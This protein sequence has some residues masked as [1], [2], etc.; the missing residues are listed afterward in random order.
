MPTPTRTKTAQQIVDNALTLLNKMMPTPT[1]TTTAKSV[2]D[3]S[4]NILNGMMPIP[5]YNRIAQNVVD[6]SLIILNKLMPQPSYTKT[7]Q[8]VVDEAIIML[9]HMMPTPTHTVTVQKIVDAALAKLNYVNPNGTVDSTRQ[10]KYYTIAIQMVNEIQADLLKKENPL[11]APVAVTD[12]TSTLSVSDNTAI[13]VMPTALA[14]QFAQADRVIDSFN[15]L[16]NEYYSDKL[17]SVKSIS[18][19]STNMYYSIAP[20][21]VNEFQNELANIENPLVSPTEIVDLTDALSVTDDTAVRVMPTA[22]AMR[23]A[24]IT[25][26]TDVYNILSVEYFKQKLPSVKAVSIGESNKYSEISIQILNEVQGDLIKIEN[27]LL[28][29]TTIMTLTDNFNVSDDTS[30]RIMPFAVAMRLAQIEGLNEIYSTLSVEYFKTKLPSVKPISVGNTNV[31]YSIALPIINAVQSELCHIEN[32]LSSPTKI[33]AL[34]DIL[35]IT[36]KTAT[37]VMPYAIAMN[38]AQRMGMADLYAT[39]SNEYY[40]LK[41]PTVEAV[42]VGES[43]VFYAI[44]IPI[45]NEFQREL[46]YKENPLQTYSEIAALT[47]ILSI[48]DDTASRV[49]TTAVAMRFAEI[50]GMNEAYANLSTEYYKQKLPNVRTISIGDGNKYYTIAIPLVNEIQGDL[51]KRENPMAV[52][53]PITALT[54]ILSVTDDT[55]VRVFPTALAMKFAQTE[56]EN[57]Y[58]VLSEEYYK[59]KLPSIQPISAGDISKYASISPM[60][61]TVLQLELLK[62]EGISET[63]DPLTSLDDVLTI[64]DATALNVLPFG[65]AARWSLT[66]D[67]AIYN[68]MTAN[69]INAKK[70]IFAA[71]TKIIDAY[72]F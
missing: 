58:K 30:T 15:V 65:L 3:E 44:S 49:L 35:S 50:R 29:P 4:L 37:C 54:G 19:G 55:A 59:Q 36:D 32:P 6:E 43:N 67:A 53:T 23:F 52:A 16:S 62:Y 21:V 51:I 25:G 9:N 18:V 31:Y 60:L 24:Q 17:P 8:D 56:N 66:E 61:C 11:V 40:K 72:N 2:V 46:L 5:T 1:K 71:P 70:S 45:L 28:T 63:P 38:F 13:R 7:A 41:L 68:D 34:T 69:Y 47:N 20:N 64:T 12:L 48:T 14:M 10:A 57:A 42:S 22:I 39:L 26:L 27:P 33:L